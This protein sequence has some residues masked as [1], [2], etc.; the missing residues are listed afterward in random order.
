LAQHY[1]WFW[2]E[3][4][5]QVGQNVCEALKTSSFFQ[6]IKN[7]RSHRKSKG[8]TF[9]NEYKT[10]RCTFRNTQSIHTDSDGEW[11]PFNRNHHQSSLSTIKSSPII[12]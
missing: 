6:S 3:E 5:L 10:W 2:S 1:G 8:Q 7:I 9:L 12:K 11:Y 4:R